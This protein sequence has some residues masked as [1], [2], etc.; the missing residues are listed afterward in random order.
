MFTFQE[1]KKNGLDSHQRENHV[2]QKKTA[3]HQ[4]ACH[5]LSVWNKGQK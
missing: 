1:A 2:D 5:D 3:E 4:Y